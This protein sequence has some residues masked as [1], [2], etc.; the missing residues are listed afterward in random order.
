M[1]L[2]RGKDGKPDPAAA[3]AL[4]RKIELGLV[5]KEALDVLHLFF[6]VVQTGPLGNLYLPPL[7]PECGPLEQPL[8]LTRRLRLVERIRNET[9][10]K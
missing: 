6:E 3:I 7:R 5:D 2:R 1:I 4:D 10:S 9:L 8:G